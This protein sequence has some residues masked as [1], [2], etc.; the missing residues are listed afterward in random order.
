MLYVL[1]VR[2]GLNSLCNAFNLLESLSSISLSNSMGGTKPLE[3][4]RQEVAQ[5]TGITLMDTV[6]SEVGVPVLGQ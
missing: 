2:A 6:L 1:G 4:L 5:C 3:Q